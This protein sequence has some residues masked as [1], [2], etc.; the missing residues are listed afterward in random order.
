MQFDNDEASAEQ[1]LLLLLQ[2]SVYAASR[3]SV[4]AIE[5]LKPALKVLDALVAK[6]PSH[7]EYH[8][9][10]ANV[11]I[12]LGNEL[13]LQRQWDEA[14]QHFEDCLADLEQ[15]HKTELTIHLFKVAGCPQQCCRIVEG[16]SKANGKKR[17]RLRASHFSVLIAR[18]RSS[19]ATRLQMECGSQSKQ[20]GSAVLAQ[21]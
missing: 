6:N 8:L 14:G 16:E 18:S 2:G 20:F 1:A 11:V 21:W 13:R 9:H 3:K 4:K 10:R 12:R 19:W 17:S 15:L 7:I 5:T